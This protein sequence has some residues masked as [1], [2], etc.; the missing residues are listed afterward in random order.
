[1]RLQH[2]STAAA[3]VAAVLV[4]HVTDRTTGQ[5]IAG[6][7]IVLSGPSHAKATT[8]SD[9]SYAVR[10]L[11]P[12]LYTLTLSSNDVPP[13]SAHLRITKAKTREDFIVCSTTLD[14]SCAPGG[15]GP[16]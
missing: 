6:V 9:G 15:D 7:H 2:L 14:Y 4:G 5:A 12:G 1:M 10:G 8:K 16:G 13:E 3:F 11:R